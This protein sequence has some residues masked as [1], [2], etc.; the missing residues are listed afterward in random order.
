[1]L[2]FFSRVLTLSYLV[3]DKYCMV[4]AYLAAE[5]QNKLLNMQFQVCANVDVL[6]SLEILP[7]AS[8]KHIQTRFSL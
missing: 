7:R 6:F 1:M 5:Q 8:E 2:D 3:Q 4:P